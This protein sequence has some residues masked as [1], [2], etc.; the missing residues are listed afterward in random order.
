MSTL[1]ENDGFEDSFVYAY[2]S[3]PEILSLWIMKKSSH[4]PLLLY[5]PL[6][7]FSSLYMEPYLNEQFSFF[8]NKDVQEINTRYQH[9]ARRFRKVKKSNCIL[10]KLLVP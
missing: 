6:I 4:Y 7:F 2:K 8:V 9:K 3:I 10:A 1:G 5:F